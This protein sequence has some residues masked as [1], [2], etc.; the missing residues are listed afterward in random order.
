MKWIL[1][2]GGVLV[3]LVVIVALVGALLPRDH[4]ATMTM[5]IP[6]PPQT[7]WDA[8]TDVRSYPAWRSDVKRVEV[9]STPPAPLSWKEHGSNGTIPFA[10]DAFE[11]P[12]RMASR[13]ADQSLP[14]GGTWEYVLAPETSDSNRTR[15]TIIE[16]GHV[17]NPVFRFVSRFVMGHHA[18]LEA[19]LRALGRKFGSDAVPLR[20]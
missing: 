18:T 10:V 14:F 20:A 5:V 19:Y 1:I 7:V 9:L 17:T 16:R 4:V 3:G 6:A 2:V 15:V 11:P 12:R 8:I 13:I